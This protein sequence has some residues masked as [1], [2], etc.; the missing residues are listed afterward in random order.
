MPTAFLRGQVADYDRWRPGFDRFDAM[1]TA[2]GIDEHFVCRNREDPNEIL[3]V[4][5][6]RTM[7]EAEEYLGSTEL[8]DAIKANGTLGPVQ[9]DLFDEA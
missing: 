9:I 1:H 8:R 3:V 6:F 2:S 7:V 5:H 4:L